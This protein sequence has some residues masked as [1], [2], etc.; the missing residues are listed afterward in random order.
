MRDA[1]DQPAREGFTCDSCGRFIVTAVE[2]LYR[3]P[4]TGS[5]T[6]FCDHSCRQAAYRRRRAGVA[7]NTPRQNN[8]GRNRGLTDTNTEAPPTQHTTQN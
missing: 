1:S 2:G 7:E 6:R 8:G 5:P 4:S 3:R